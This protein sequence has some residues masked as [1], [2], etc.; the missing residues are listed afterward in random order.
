M[1]EINPVIP[2]CAGIAGWVF[3]ERNSLVYGMSYMGLESGTKYLSIRHSAR[4][5]GARNQPHRRWYYP[6][7]PYALSPN[8]TA[9]CKQLLDSNL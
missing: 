9:C 8:N 4:A 2:A 3:S 7:T 1:N 6:R 5:T